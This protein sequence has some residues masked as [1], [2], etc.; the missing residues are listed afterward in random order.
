MTSFSY[1]CCCSDQGYFGYFSFSLPWEQFLIIL[2]SF[3]KDENVL[4]EKWNRLDNEFP[5]MFT[6]IISLFLHFI[7]V[8]FIL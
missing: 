7:L 2:S 1:F 4:S 3:I 8:E 5:L 6:N